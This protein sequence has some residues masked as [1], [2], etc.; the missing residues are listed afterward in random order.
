MSTAVDCFDAV[1]GEA[2]ETGLKLTEARSRLVGVAVGC[3]IVF[4]GGKT[5]DG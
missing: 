1:T 4:A 2:V 5:L 3:T